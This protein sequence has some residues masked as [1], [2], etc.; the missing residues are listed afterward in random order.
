MLLFILLGASFGCGC[1]S[2]D[3][4]AGQEAAR[5]AAQN[6]YMQQMA[7]PGA[8]ARTYLSLYTTHKVEC[9][10]GNRFFCTQAKVDLA[11]I[12]RSWQQALAIVEDMT[13]DP[14]LSDQ[15]HKEAQEMAQRIRASI[16]SIQSAK[17]GKLPKL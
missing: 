8:D 2:T 6:G 16:Q 13:R 17:P 4:A 3:G 7:G 15:D 5:K 1:D 11:H 12:E 9:E 10:S 14:A